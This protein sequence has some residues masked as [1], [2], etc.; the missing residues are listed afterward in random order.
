[1]IGAMNQ[2]TL[3]SW[4][5]RGQQDGYRGIFG[6]AT[7]FLERKLNDKTFLLSMEL[8]FGCQKATHENICGPHLVSECVLPTRRFVPFAAKLF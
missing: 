3:Q 5:R 2:E 6:T 7:A 4:N 1:M 8:S